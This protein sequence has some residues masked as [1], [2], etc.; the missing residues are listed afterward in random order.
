MASITKYDGAKGITYKATIRMKGY[1]TQTAT[2][3]RKTDADRWAKEV[4]TA[5]HHGKHFETI[6]AKKHTA[7]ELIDK[8][9]KEELPKKP[10]T[11][12]GQKPQLEWWK[13]E[14]GVRTLADVTPE[15]IDEC[16]KKLLEQKTYKGTNMS[17]STVN[18]YLAALSHV[19]TRAVKTWRWIDKTPFTQIE[20]ET[21]PK[22]RVRYLSDDERNRLLDACKSSDNKHLYLIVLLAIATG[23]R[24]NEIMGLSWENVSFDLKRI[25]LIDTKN[26]DTRAVPLAGEAFKLLKEHSKVRRIDTPLVFPRPGAKG[27]EESMAIRRAWD[28]AIVTAKIDNFRFHDLRHSCASYL[29]MNGASMAEIA[30]VLGHRT[31][32]MAKRYAHISEQHTLSVIEK[33]NQKIFGA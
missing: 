31:L 25:I 6:K 10:K 32:E 29:A 4:E 5:I 19:F 18:R 28:N 23:A 22:G 27:K 33:M 2:F 26:G 1:P 21:E 15:L 8:Y 24:K 3:K 16:K 12:E 11:A 30:A 14:I 9:I 20:K 13:N 7:A 17:G